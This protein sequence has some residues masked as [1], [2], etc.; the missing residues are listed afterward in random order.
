MLNLVDRGANS[1][2]ELPK[3][4]EAAAR[5]EQGVGDSGYVLLTFPLGI[6]SLLLQARMLG[7][8]TEGLSQP[9]ALP[10]FLHQT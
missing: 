2:P 5:E 9:T 1:G 7:Q 3:P 8:R 10:M 6:H 4:L